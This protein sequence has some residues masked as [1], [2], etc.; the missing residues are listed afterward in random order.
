MQEGHPGGFPNGL[1]I[2]R[3]IE[4]NKTGFMRL[5]EEMSTAIDS[6]AKFQT[7]MVKKM[8]PKAGLVD[9]M[10][11]FPISQ[12]CETTHEGMKKVFAEMDQALRFFLSSR[13]SSGKCPSKC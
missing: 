4:D 2:V 7:S 9:K 11:A 8:N 1:P 3:P 13:E 10:F 6:A 12:H 5:I